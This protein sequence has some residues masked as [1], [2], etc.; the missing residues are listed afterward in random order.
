MPAPFGACRKRCLPNRK[1]FQRSGRPPNFAEMLW[2]RYKIRSQTHTQEPPIWSDSKICRPATRA[3]RRNDRYSAQTMRVQTIRRNDPCGVARKT[4]TERQT[5]KP[6]TLQT[7]QRAA[8][9]ACCAS[10][11]GRDNIV[12]SASR[13][14]LGPHQAIYAL[15]YSD[16]GI[17]TKYM[18]TTNTQIHQRNCDH[19]RNRRRLRVCTSCL[20]LGDLT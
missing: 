14:T 11:V 4:N 19:M 15:N 1:Y 5:S 20:S 6:T 2:Q 8:A 16:T 9:R 3:Q 7:Q 17:A 18:H 13:Y 10:S 12:L